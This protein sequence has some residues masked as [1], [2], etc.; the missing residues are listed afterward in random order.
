[1]WIQVGKEIRK[2][3][4]PT[5]YWHVGSCYVNMAIS[6]FFPQNIITF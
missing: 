4:I 3:N 1:M 5:M 6:V 2:I